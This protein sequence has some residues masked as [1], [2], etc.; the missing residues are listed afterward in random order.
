VLLGKKGS[1]NVGNI[2]QLLRN[3]TTPRP[4]RPL[5]V[6]RESEI[7]QIFYCQSFAILNF[8]VALRLGVQ[9][10]RVVIAV[11][12]FDVSELDLFRL[13]GLFFFH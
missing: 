12:R 13:T 8:P 3:Y 11:S 6:Q 2:S 4:R 10:A 1:T 9:T 7:S 5:P